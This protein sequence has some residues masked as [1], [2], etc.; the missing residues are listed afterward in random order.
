MDELYIHVTVLHRNRFLFDNQ[1][2]ALNI[3]IYSVIKLYMFRAYSLPIIRSFILY[4]RYW[5]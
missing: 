4:I 5:G 3:Q 1:Q 2:D